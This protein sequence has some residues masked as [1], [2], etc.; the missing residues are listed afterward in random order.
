M[1][2]GSHCMEFGVTGLQGPFH[3]RLKDYWSF[4]S[5][6][7]DGGSA[8]YRACVNSKTCALKC[9]SSSLANHARNSHR[10]ELQLCTRMITQCLISDSQ[11]PFGLT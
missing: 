2:N 9:K 3:R 5:L 4:D 7:R 1:K 6:Y 10:Y 8:T 11:R